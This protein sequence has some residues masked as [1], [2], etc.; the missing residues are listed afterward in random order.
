MAVSKNGLDLIGLSATKLAGKKLQGFVASL[1]YVAPLIA[2]C[3]I[4]YAGWALSVALFG[5]LTAGYINY[6]QLLMAGE[7]PSYLLIF[8]GKGDIIA[9]ILLGIILVAGFALGSVLLIVP[10]MIFAAYFSMSFFFLNEDRISNVMDSLSTCARRMSG[11]KTSMASYKLI[12]Y[13][14]YLI[15]G[16]FFGALAFIVYQLVTSIALAVVL[17][18][19]IILVFIAVVAGCTMF[20][21]AANVVFYEEIKEY[22]AAHPKAT[23]KKT[24]AAKKEESKSVEVA[25]AKPAAPKPEAKPATPAKKPAASAKP[26][27]KKTATKKP[28]P[29]TTK[30]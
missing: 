18:S 26:V 23:K 7:K 6:M 25:P 16:L 21:Y 10:G 11:S 24:V 15:I 8:K 14:Y 13:L 5:Y 29:K 20:F 17:Y 27:A 2:L 9:S 3:F 1:I 30:K 28:A 22:V 19:L 12:F 4:P